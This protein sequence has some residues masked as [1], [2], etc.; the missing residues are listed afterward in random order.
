MMPVIADASPSCLS[1]WR[2]SQPASER[3]HSG[4]DRLP[5]RRSLNVHRS[6]VCRSGDLRNKPVGIY[7]LAVRLITSTAPTLGFCP[8]DQES[9]TLARSGGSWHQPW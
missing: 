5:C 8:S 7:S 9:V 6:P 3:I 1:Y 4:L 2:S